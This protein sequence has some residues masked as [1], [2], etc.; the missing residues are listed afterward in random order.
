MRGT[1][2]TLLFFAFGYSFS[3]SVVLVNSKT[4][5]NDEIQIE[6]ILQDSVTSRLFTTSLYALT[7]TGA[8]ELKEIR[9]DFGEDIAVGNHVVTWNALKELGRYRGKIA[10]Q[11]KAT[12]QFAFLTP[13]D[14][15]RSKKGKP[16]EFRWYGE[17]S[18]M[19]SLRVELY[20]FDQLVDT[21]GYIGNQGT[22]TWEIP[23]GI[24]PSQ[25]YRIRIIGTEK[26]GINRFSPRVIV[27]R[28]IPLPYQ[29]AGM[30]VAGAGVL[31]TIILLLRAL[32]PIGGPN[33]R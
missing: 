9:G 4:I 16:V 15:K 29:Y 3:Q 6:Y 11:V 1:I 26:S 14:N 22:Y 20:R 33:G 31:T 13:K 23:E 24:K 27:D 2:L 25:G 28:K 8:F 17:N 32:P 12:P 18:T 7:D 10:I 19:D 5:E 21:L 30:G